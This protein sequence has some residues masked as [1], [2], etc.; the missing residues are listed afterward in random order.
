MTPTTRADRPLVILGPTASGKS[1][2]ALA[3]AN[4]IGA[5]E[6]VSIDS[7]AVYR[8]MDI[9]TAAPTA[10][11]RD[12]VPHHLIDVA[13]PS[14]EFTVGVF[15]RMALR[16][17]A[18]IRERGNTP[19]LVGG[20]GL[21]LRA[22]VDDLKLP[23]RYPEIAAELD[24]EPDTELLHARLTLLDPTAASRME[25]SNRRRVLRALEV[26]IGSGT[27]FSS[28]GPGLK[29]YG[30]TPFVMVALR[31]PQEIL[32]ERISARYRDQMEAGFLD[33]VRALA[34]GEVSRTAA[35][36]LGYREFLAHVAGECTLEEA[37]ATAIKR[38]R[39]F[40]RRQLRWFRRDPRIC[41]IDAPVTGSE[42]IGHWDEQRILTTG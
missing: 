41:W 37:L 34:A 19:I 10:S 28:F 36:A 4:E 14:E 5:A 9:G 33:E 35:Q 13:D 23:G 18:E 16:A 24:A 15:K 30:P 42:M 6:I 21:Y 38:T 40:A 20:T 39:R 12:Q 26:T 22:V 3:I 31:W 11:D 27:L 29:H 25:P 17:I 7:M 2:L 32:D 1:S 8:G